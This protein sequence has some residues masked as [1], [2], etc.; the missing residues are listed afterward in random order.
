MSLHLNLCRLGQYCGMPQRKLSV[1]KRPL[2]TRRKPRRAAATVQL[3][4]ARVRSENEELHAENEQLR[5]SHREL[6]AV[7]RRYADLYDF[8]PFGCLSLDARGFILELN[9]RA[10]AMLGANRFNAVGKRLQSYI[11][12]GD[13]ENFRSHLFQAKQSRG[14]ARAELRLDA[15]GGGVL[16]VQMVTVAAED[17][18]RRM[19][20]VTCSIADITERKRA[21]Q[22]LAASEEQYRVLFERN[23][24]P[25][26]I[27]NRSTLRW[28]AVNHAALR[29]FGYSLDEFLGMSV[30][31]IRAP[32]SSDSWLRAE[33]DRGATGERAK[34]VGVW[35]LRRKDGT[36]IDVEVTRS[37]VFFQAKSAWLV[38]AHDVTARLPFDAALKE[39]E[40]R[41]QSTLDT[42]AAGICTTD[43]A[44]RFLQANRAFCRFLGYSETELI[45]LRFA[46]VTHPDDIHDLLL[47]L[48]ELKTGAR[49]VVHLEKRFLCKNLGTVWGHVV[50]V[51]HFAAHRKPLY[52]QVVVRD[53]TERMG[54][55][56]GLRESEARLQAIFDISPA[57]IFMK[58]TKGRYLSVNRQFESAY[59]VSRTQVIGRTDHELFDPERA[60]LTRINDL[61]VLESGAPLETDEPFLHN[62]VLHTGLVCRFPVRDTKGNIY[63]IFGTATERTPWHAPNGKPGRNVRI[64]NSLA[65]QLIEVQEAE[66]RHIARELHDQVGQVLTAL[67]LS[68]RISP[69]Q[70]S[71]KIRTDVK[72]AEALVSDLTT[73]V[74]DLSLT[75]RPSLLDDLGLLPALVWHFDRYTEQT[76]V[77]VTFKHSGIEGKRFQPE[78]ETAAYRIVQESLTNVA[79]HAGVT[80]VIVRVWSDPERLHIQVED[81][82]KG[83]DPEKASLGTQS[84]G[85]IG[86]RERA[87]LLG[88]EFT[89]D[90]ACGAGTCLTASLAIG[91]V[92]RKSIHEIDHCPG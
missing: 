42:V 77:R 26:W 19:K 46:D 50:A 29:L 51:L 33:H 64:E 79:R 74:R 78:T 71:E 47:Q 43:P 4:L 73:R 21:E 3:S 56:E 31:D 89:I 68:L 61:K 80:E 25:M 12:K 13:L 86:M 57:A 7:R 58:D 92:A 11:W 16:W 62:G 37:P 35:K 14:S 75:L 23:P 60:A 32:A 85:L 83:F 49:D 40:T 44:G 39:N 9:L 76:Q 52:F 24:H 17:P 55:T 72:R 65:L 53:I 81:H 45:K 66:R 82:G 69:D 15:G 6:D 38:L 18:E 28:M 41:F 8:A 34:L 67:K 20:V 30:K 91:E 36:L 1:V 48:D 5:A 88:G 22:D 54:A 84:R 59:A 2:V 10:A 90:S 70:Q 87:N 63:A 27:Y